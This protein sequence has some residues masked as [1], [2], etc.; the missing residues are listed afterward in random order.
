[1]RKSE[2]Q[3]RQGTKVRFYSEPP[4]LPLTQEQVDAFIALMKD[5]VCVRSESR[6]EEDNGQAT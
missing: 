6:G 5:E 4:D 1:M 3:G 2:E